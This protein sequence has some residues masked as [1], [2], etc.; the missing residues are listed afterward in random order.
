[1]VP[2]GRRSYTADEEDRC[3][4]NVRITCLPKWTAPLPSR[5]LSFFTRFRHKPDTMQIMHQS[6]VIFLSHF[7][8]LCHT[9]FRSIRTIA[10][11]TLSLWTR[12]SQAAILMSKKA[13][14][15]FS[16]SQRC[17]WSLRC[18]ERWNRVTR[19]LMADVL[20]EGVG[21]VFKGLNAH[22]FTRLRRVKIWREYLYI[23]LN[24]NRRRP[25]SHIC[26]LWGK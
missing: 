7:C 16:L 20:G 19:W 6:S 25:C 26:T 11:Q 4:R 2:Q 15:L 13:V 10:V 17:S 5:L 9:I 21:R 18:S 23:F 14:P 1:M 3:F 24:F 22:F 12:T 8:S